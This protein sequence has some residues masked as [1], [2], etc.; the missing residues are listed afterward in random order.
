MKREILLNLPMSKEHF[1]T[2]K[3]TSHKI[4]SYTDKLNTLLNKF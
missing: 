2:L 4:N 3:G 1:A